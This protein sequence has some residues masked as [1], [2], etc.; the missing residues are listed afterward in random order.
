[1]R[2]KLKKK[3]LSIAKY[4]DLCVCYIYIS[5]VSNKSAQMPNSWVV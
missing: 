1:M 5:N 2:D 4:F 3:N